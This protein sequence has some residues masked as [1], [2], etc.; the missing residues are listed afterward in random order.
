MQD[1]VERIVEMD[2]RAREL[3]DEAKKLRVGSED[4]LRAKK[5]ALRKGY[6]DRANDRVEMI[7]KAEVKNA[8]TELK[9][10]LEKQ[11]QAQQRLDDRYAEMGDE[12]VARIVARV[13]GDEK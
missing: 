7:K 1:M 4:R 9:S 6:Q 8:E 11:K 13:T 5:E 12:W 10:I 2:K 3:T